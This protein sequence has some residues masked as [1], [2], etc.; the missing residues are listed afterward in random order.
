MYS[1]RALLVGVELLEETITVLHKQMSIL[2]TKVD[3]KA[4]LPEEYGRSIAKQCLDMD[5]LVTEF[6]R[7]SKMLHFELLPQRSHFDADEF[8]E[9]ERRYARI[10]KL[11]S[12]TDCV[13]RALVAREISSNENRH[14]D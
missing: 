2:N 3:Q 6:K 13:L 9:V 14:P 5:V 4:A 8:D 11:L 12:R 10:E 1:L 7:L